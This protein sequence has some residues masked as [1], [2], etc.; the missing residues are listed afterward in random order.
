MFSQIRSIPDVRSGPAAPSGADWD[1]LAIPILTS[2]FDT[3]TNGTSLLV[4]GGGGGII[5]TDGLNWTNANVPTL[6]GH[7]RGVKWTGSQ[8]ISAGSRTV[9]WSTN[10]TSWNSATVGNAQLQDLDRSPSGRTVAVGENNNAYWSDNLTSWNPCNLP[11]TGSG[12]VYTFIPAI[13]YSTFYNKWFCAARYEVNPPTNTNSFTIQLSSND[14]ITWAEHA[15]YTGHHLLENG[16][17]RILMSNGSDSLVQTTNG[18]SWSGFQPQPASQGIGAIYA[19]GYDSVTDKYITARQTVLNGPGSG[20]V[21]TATGPV[22]DSNGSLAWTEESV[23]TPFN[24]SSQRPRGRISINNARIAVIAMDNVATPT[25]WRS[26]RS[27]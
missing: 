24:T 22:L 7:V 20:K 23:N 15:L 5:S 27:P 1:E 26:V 2:S 12:R 18:T 17:G 16:S 3:A 21:R 25:I 9:G 4:V 19:I 6:G 14:G 11:G 10:G 13:I 8:F